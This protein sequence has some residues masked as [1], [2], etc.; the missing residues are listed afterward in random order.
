MNNRRFAS[1]TLVVASIVILASVGAY[2][3]LVKKL[4][5]RPSNSIVQPITNKQLIQPTHLPKTTPTQ[6]S[7][8][9]PTS[10]I[11]RSNYG[12]E[13]QYPKDWELF[14]KFDSKKEDAEA[15][16]AFSGV[17]FSPKGPHGAGYD[18]KF[19]ISIYDKQFSDVEPITRGMGAQFTDRQ[20]K[21][22]SIMI[23][24]LPALKVIVTTPS[25]P[26]WY[27]EEVF[28]ES[29]DYI[30]EISNGAIKDDLFAKFYSS[31]RFSK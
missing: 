4:S 1:I 20:E 7:G 18:G 24:G 29:Q 25:I 31:F 14:S 5:V 23:N 30:Y 11:Y 17:T 27:L 28:I 9:L 8:T 6:T 19:F 16:T 3:I 22:E 13:V 15:L 21:R 10:Q 12:F 26:D 2:F